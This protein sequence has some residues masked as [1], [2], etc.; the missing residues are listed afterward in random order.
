MRIVT[1][2]PGDRLISSMDNL[3]GEMLVYKREELERIQPLAKFLS[4]HSVYESPSWQYDILA[5]AGRLY[6]FIEAASEHKG[7]TVYIDPKFK[8][9]KRMT[10]DTFRQELGRNYLGIFKRDG[11]PA[12]PDVVMVDGSYPE[13]KE[14]L[15]YVASLMESDLFKNLSYWTEGALL[16]EAVK[17]HPNLPVKNLSGQF[18]KEKEP[19]R[20]TPLGEYLES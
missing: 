13:H 20:C 11:M 12:K 15:E 14:F 3:P 18:S 17:R 10:E 16:D 8:V 1:V 7:L 4:K 9:V 19:L 6:P 5:A 2:N